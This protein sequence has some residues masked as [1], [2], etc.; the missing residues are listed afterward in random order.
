MEQVQPD[1]LPEELWGAIRHMGRAVATLGEMPI[2][3]TQ[4][5]TLI[6]VFWRWMDFVE[7]L[8]AWTGPTDV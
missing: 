5:P 3:E 6:L 1:V 4:Q 8:E 7:V 2:T